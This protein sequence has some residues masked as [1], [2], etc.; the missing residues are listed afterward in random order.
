MKA[1]ELIAKMPNLTAPAPAVTRLLQVLSLPDADHDDVICIVK[2]DGVLSAKLLAICNSARFGLAEPVG[3]VEQAVFYLGHGE[4]H[5]LI[6][7]ISFGVAL[8][9]TLP[10]YVIEDGELWRHSLVTAYATERVLK[11]VSSVSL[12][13]SIA[14]PAGLLHDIGKVVISHALNAENQQ[15]I[16][17]IVERGGHSLLEVEREVLGADHAEIGACLL[18]QWRLPDNIVEAVANHHAPPVKPRPQLSAIVHVADIMAHQVGSSPGIG[19]FAARPDEA[20]IEAL[21][22]GPVEIQNLVV[23]TLDALDAV[24]EILALA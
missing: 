4:I 1:E 20:A 7:A 11:A 3:S 17:Q 19:S 22:L 10:G 14:Y 12:E 24:K 8:S 2:Q 13:P 6:M 23:E 21:G 18:R 15:L 9:P 5:R 16:R